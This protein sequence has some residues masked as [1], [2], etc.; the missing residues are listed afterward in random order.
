M[1]HGDRPD[2]IDHAEPIPPENEVI[3]PVNPSDDARAAWDRLAPGLIG[4]GVV[5]VWDVDAFV[6]VR[7][8]LAWSR[9]PF[10]LAPWQRKDIVEL[11]SAKSCGI[12]NG[13]PSSAASRSAGSSWRGRTARASCWRSPRSS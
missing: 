3:A 13:S 2:R 10:E 11:R 6:V 7:E 4:V 5:T 8:A 1:L 9:R 12:R